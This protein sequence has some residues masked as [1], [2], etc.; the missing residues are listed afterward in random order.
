MATQ[1]PDRKTF[2]PTQAAGISQELNP[3]KRKVKAGVVT[4]RLQETGFGNIPS[5]CLRCNLPAEQCPEVDTD[6][7][8]CRKR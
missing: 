5:R 8:R 2:T 3:L 4:S 7:P 6:L 1:L